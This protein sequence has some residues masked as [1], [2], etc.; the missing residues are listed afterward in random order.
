MLVGGVLNVV[1]NG[2]LIWMGLYT[3]VTAVS[4]TLI[5]EIVVMGIMFWFIRNRLE[6]DFHFFTR[7]NIKY[8]LLSLLFV[9]ITWLVKQL[10][11]GMIVNCIVI[12]PICILV[13][14]GALLLLKD[15]TMLF[16]TKKVLGKFITKLKR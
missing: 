13:Y 12:V 15:E 7:T 1:L 4:T 11:F 2:L 16:L 9:P 8:I 14:F 5:A 10:G 3:P 6:I